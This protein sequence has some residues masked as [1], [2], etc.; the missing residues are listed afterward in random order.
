MLV[1]SYALV[2]DPE[3]QQPLSLRLE[4]ERPRLM[5]ALGGALEVSGEIDARGLADRRTVRGTLVT[6][7]LSADYDLGFS[8]NAGH[9][10]RLRAARRG[11][12]RD[13]L[14]SLSRVLGTL[15]DADGREIARVELRLDFRQALRLLNKL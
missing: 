13:P 11:R 6:S 9:E 5:P 8:S 7:P 1:G 2:A 14:F 12:W 15:S 4:S 3:R 10:L